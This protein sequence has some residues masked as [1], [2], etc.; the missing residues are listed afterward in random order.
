MGR[1]FRFSGGNYLSQ[2]K[3]MYSLKGVYILFQGEDLMISSDFENDFDEL[4]KGDV[5]EI[6]F[7]PNPSEPLYFEYE[8][9]PLEKEMVLLMVKKDTFI[10]GWKPWPYDKESRVLKKINIIGGVMKAYVPIKSWKA[11]LFF[12]YSLLSPF[13]NIPPVKGTRWKANFC[14]LDYDTGKII[15]WAWA[16][17]EESFHET[18]RYFP[19]LFE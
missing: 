19:L 8:I 1:T 12:P 15:K 14:R 10:S 18:E 13:L 4:F 17:V 16:P 6:F 9:S 3:I 7:H 11:E 5:F 2:F